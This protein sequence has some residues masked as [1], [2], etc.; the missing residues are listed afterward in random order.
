MDLSFSLNKRASRGGVAMD[1]FRSRILNE[2][3]VKTRMRNKRSR[4]LKIVTNNIFQ[5][6]VCSFHLFLFN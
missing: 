1:N 3:R 5:F 4:T 2:Q 6:D